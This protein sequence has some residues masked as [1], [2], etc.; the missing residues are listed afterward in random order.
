MAGNR[1][2]DI[3]QAQA[4]LNKS[5]VT[6]RQATED[7]RRTQRLYAEQAISQQALTTALSTHDGAQAQVDRPAEYR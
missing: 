2:E 7:L 5:Q 4:N 6:H 3:A 1:S